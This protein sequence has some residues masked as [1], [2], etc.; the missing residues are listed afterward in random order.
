MYRRRRTPGECIM[1]ENNEAARARIVFRV[2]E[3]RVVFFYRWSM[4]ERVYFC[5]YVD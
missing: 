4:M 2:L 5:N 1:E 3:L